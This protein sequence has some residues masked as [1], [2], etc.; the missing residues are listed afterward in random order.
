MSMKVG[1][2]VEYRGYNITFDYPPIPIRTI[3]YSFFHDDYDGAPEH[4][5]DGFSSD[6][7][8]GQ[9]A[10]VDDCKAQIDEQ[11]LESE[12]DGK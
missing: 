3:D 10:S 2:N 4:L 7:R 12:E 1:E 5:Y 6:T 11:I 8:C 9:G